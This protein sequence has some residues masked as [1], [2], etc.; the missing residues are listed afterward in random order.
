LHVNE[1]PQIPA[2]HRQEKQR[3][4]R[5]REGAALSFPFPFLHI[6]GDRLTLEFIGTYLNSMT[7]TSQSFADVG[8]GPASTDRIILI[9]ALAHRGTSAISFS[10]A[11][12]GGAAASLLEQQQASGS[13]NN[14]SCAVFAALVPAGAGG[15][16]VTNTA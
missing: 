16:I 14:M 3:G 10:S 1:R 4:D 7:G 15:T 8:F 2:S 11:T 13:S 6:R 12:I 5:N 9:A